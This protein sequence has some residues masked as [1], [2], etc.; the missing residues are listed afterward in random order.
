MIVS[1]RGFS[2]Q[3]D[4]ALVLARL[5]VTFLGNICFGLIGTL[6]EE[7]PTSWAQFWQDTWVRKQ[8][9]LHLAGVLKPFPTKNI[10]KVANIRIR[11]NH[12]WPEPGCSSQIRHRNVFFERPMDILTKICMQAKIYPE[13]KI[14]F[15]QSFFHRF[16]LISLCLWHEKSEIRGVTK[17]VAD[18]Y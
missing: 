5:K 11:L 3:T 2:D 6:K 8:Y 4:C 14:T 9:K 18:F 10:S 7:P 13:T 17:I 1:E 15:L 12:M 16:R